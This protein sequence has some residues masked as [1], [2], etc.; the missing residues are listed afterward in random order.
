MVREA[1]RNGSQWSVGDGCDDGVCGGGGD[2]SVDL[3]ESENVLV[4]AVILSWW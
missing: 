3:A 2:G 1:R 4:M